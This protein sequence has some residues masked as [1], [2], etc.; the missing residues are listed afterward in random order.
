MAAVAVPR[1]SFWPLGFLRDFVTS[2]DIHG[3]HIASI[4]CFF[5]RETMDR[6]QNCKHNK[7]AHLP[8]GCG[9]GCAVFQPANAPLVFN[10]IKA[11]E[12][13]MQQIEAVR[14]RRSAESWTSTATLGSRRNT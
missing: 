4:L 13:I 6:C 7:A 8:N 9:C 14:R 2:G 1:Y 11:G 5:G 10:S 12:E 3:S